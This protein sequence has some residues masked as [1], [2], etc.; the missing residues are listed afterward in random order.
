M[1]STRQIPPSPDDELTKRLNELD[2]KDVEI[3]LKTGETIVGRLTMNT[4][5]KPITTVSIGGK[6]I[7]ISNISVIR[8]RGHAIGQS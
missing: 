7:S 1:T 6:Q 4:L 3:E 5:I 8:A 2:G